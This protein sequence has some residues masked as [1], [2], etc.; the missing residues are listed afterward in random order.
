MATFYQERKALGKCYL[1]GV[2]GKEHPTTHIGP[3]VNLGCEYDDG[4]YQIVRQ[5]TACG[6]QW[7]YETDDAAECEAVNEPQAGRGADEATG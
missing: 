7:T 1:F 4:A 5:C 2:D 6:R 3:I